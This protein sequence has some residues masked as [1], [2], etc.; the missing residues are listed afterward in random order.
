MTKF[1]SST[2][3]VQRSKLAFGFWIL[4]FLIIFQGCA[5]I[6]D[7]SSLLYRNSRFEKG[8][9]DNERVGLMPMFGKGE[10]RAYLKNAENIFGQSLTDEKK[11]VTF[12]S[13]EES[14]ERIRSAGLIE[15]YREMAR[16]YSPLASQKLSDI[17]VIGG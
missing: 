8:L 4:S 14:L 12:L 10:N 3:K 15:T 5:G 6:D 9:L 13:P 16:S 7:L 11:G 1:Q 17:Q 2:F